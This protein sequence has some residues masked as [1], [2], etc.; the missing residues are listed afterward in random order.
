MGAHE[1][2]ADLYQGWLDQHGTDGGLDDARTA[3]VFA[4]LAWIRHVEGDPTA[5]RS[6][7]DQALDAFEQAGRGDPKTATLLGQVA[8][9]IGTRRPDLAAAQRDPPQTDPI[10]L[11]AV[12]AVGEPYTIEATFYVTSNGESRV[13]GTGDRIAVGD[14]LSLVVDASRDLW[15]YIL[16]EDERGAAFVMFPAAGF[17]PTNPLPPGEHVLPGVKDGQR[18][19]WRVSSSGGREHIL[20]IASPAPLA[21]LE[22]ELGTAPVPQDAPLFASLRSEAAERLRGIGE[23]AVRPAGRLPAKSQRLFDRA[24]ALAGKAEQARGLW[25]RQIDLENPGT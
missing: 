10:S 15:V 22:S 13:V 6:F 9:A 16:N 20:I 7:Y 12:P 11:T 17:A 24:K 14:T 1:A 3:E 25:I 23:F 2:A 4:Q 8:A 19:D 5:A 18:L 21:D